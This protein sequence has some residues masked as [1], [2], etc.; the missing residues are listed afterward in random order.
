VQ[1]AEELAA[2]EAARKAAEEAAALI[3]RKARQ[4]EKKAI[5]KERSKL[6]K[7]CGVVDSGDMEAPISVDEDAV[8]SLCAGLALVDLQVIPFCVSTFPKG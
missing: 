5:Q 8:E 2:Q 3:A 1:E 4:H 6:R 7:L